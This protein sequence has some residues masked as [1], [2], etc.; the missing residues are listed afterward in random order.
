MKLGRIAS[1]SLFSMLLTGPVAYAQDPVA[2]MMEQAKRQYRNGRFQA[3][4]SDLMRVTEEAPDRADAFYLIGYCHLMMRQY[5][6]S[7]NAFARAFEL[8]P[9]F[10]PRTI[11]QASPTP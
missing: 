2:D 10:D 3:A 8:D 11:Y 7:L 6:E 9:E 5:P 4:L 1:V